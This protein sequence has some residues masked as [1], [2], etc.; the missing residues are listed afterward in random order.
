MRRHLLILLS[1]GAAMFFVVWQSQEII[2][3]Y[4][5]LSTIW[6][7]P[8][9]YFLKEK[10]YGLLVV[11][12]TGIFLLHGWFFRIDPHPRMILLWTVQALLFFGFFS[13][14]TNGLPLPSMRTSTSSLPHA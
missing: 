1:L 6:L 4:Y 13:S 14:I 5:L 9:F 7:L 2:L 10:V 3:A 12:A 8:L 11:T